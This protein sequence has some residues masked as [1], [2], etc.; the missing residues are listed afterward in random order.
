MLRLKHE[1]DMKLT[2]KNKKKMLPNSSFYYKKERMN[3]V[4]LIALPH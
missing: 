2:K 4:V 3:Q 1:K